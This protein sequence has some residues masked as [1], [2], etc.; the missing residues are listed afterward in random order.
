LIWFCTSKCF[1]QLVLISVEFFLSGIL[2]NKQKGFD[3]FISAAEFL[4][5]QGR[6]L[7]NV[8]ADI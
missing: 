7:F 6:L 8:I 3:D 2:H 1:H 5:S 4:V